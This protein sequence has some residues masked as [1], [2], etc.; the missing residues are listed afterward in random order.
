MTGRANRSSGSAVR[1]DAA[2][3][4]P[5][6]HG[7]MPTAADGSL[8]DRLLSATLRCVARWGTVKTTLADIAREAGCSRAT[9]YRAFPGGKEAVLVA[10]GEREVRRVLSEL[11]EVAA[12]C[13]S[14]EEL[15]GETLAAGVSAIRHHEVLSY[16]RQHEP[17]SVLPYVSFDGMDPLLAVVRAVLSPQIERF[18]DPSSAV[19]VAEWLARIG[20]SYGFDPLDG[21]D[22]TDPDTARAFT[23]TFLL[24]GFE[25]AAPKE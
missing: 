13:E 8:E 25:P 4:G 20:I 3:P 19:E 15:I 11:A 2:G 22:L 17:N 10:A 5:R 21:P 9:V 23:T 24:P 12:R 7:A 18:L 1:G 14:I 6:V 16:L